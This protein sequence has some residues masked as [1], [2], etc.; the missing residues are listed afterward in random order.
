M[1]LKKIF[2]YN[3]IIMGLLSTGSFLLFII[4]SSIEE[5]EAIK[6]GFLYDSIGSE[7]LLLLLITAVSIVLAFVSALLS[8]VASLFNRK[9]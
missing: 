7:Y 8:L 5:N 4:L 9:K 2:Y 3:S 1:K 6:A